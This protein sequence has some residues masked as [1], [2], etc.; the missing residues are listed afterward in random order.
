VNLFAAAEPVSLNLPGA[1]IRYWPALPLQPDTSVWRDSLIAQTPWRQES[2]EVWGR[3]HPQPRL[4]AWYGDDGASYAYSGLS[5]APLRWTP[6]LASIKQQVE[7]CCEH[8]FNSV[9][10]NYYRD[11]RDSMGMHADDEPELGP[12]PVIASLSL[13]EQRVLR[14]RHRYDSGEPAVKLPLDDGSLL[15]MSGATQRNW[16]HGIDKLS[17]FC[18]PRVNL[19]F[20]RIVTAT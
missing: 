16:K 5:L 9:L 1:E 12:E 19:T 7:A 11:H 4:T 20:R 2:I 13:G 17:R 3:T 15:L 10:L 6:L 14:F 18:G 8:R